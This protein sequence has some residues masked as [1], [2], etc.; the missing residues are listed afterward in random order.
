[1]PAH[2]QDVD[3]RQHAVWALTVL[4]LIAVLVVAVTI[5]L[6]GNDKNSHGQRIQLS[7]PTGALSTSP[8]TSGLAS[9]SVPPPGPPVTT[10][11][12]KT[13]AKATTASASP[14]HTA[15][16]PVRVA[17]STAGAP[18]PCQSDGPCV[19]AGDAGVESA[20]NTERRQQGVGG[21]SVAV[22]DAAAECAAGQPTC[23]GQYAQQNEPSQDGARAV[24]DLLSGPDT[25]AWLLS[26]GTTSLAVG[27]A[28]NPSLGEYICVLMQ[29]LG[30]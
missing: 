11:V 25:A 8:P 16:P 15:A 28:Y 26:P 19:V 9:E 3:E 4:V 13:S 10:A 23:G 14:S 18:D 20:L 24:A 17:S 5:F 29:Q 7:G 22:S 2:R 1:V 6:S 21:V 27:W 30:V 12:A